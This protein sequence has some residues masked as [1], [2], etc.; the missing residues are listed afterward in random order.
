MSRKAAVLFAEGFE[1]IEAV[2]PVDILRRAGIETLMAGV[3][4]MEVVGVHGIP[5][6]VDVPVEKLKGAEFDLLVLPGG[7]PGSKRLGSSGEARRATE[8]AFRSGRLVAAICAA[9]V[10]T[11]SA[12][13]LLS[14]RRATCYP[15]MENQFAD[16]VLFSP[17][18]VVRDGNIIT[19]RGAGVALD[20]SLALAA[21][22]AGEAAA[23]KLA[24][25]VM[26]CTKNERP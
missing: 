26:F 18:N 3:A 4:G 17:E 21:A 6:R 9:P 12:W 16:D 19:S 25:T 14:G 1:E 24:A 13:G 23:D 10:Y 5:I 11:L 2:T 7:G 8:E 20:F 22:L 15:G